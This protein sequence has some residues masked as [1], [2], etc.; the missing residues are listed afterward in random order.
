MTAADRVLTAFDPGYVLELVERLVAIPSVSGDE[1]AIS[2][3]LA[4]E[5][6]RLG[7]AVTVQEVL[8]GRRN[9]L[10][11][12]DTGRPGPSLLFNG[13]LDTLPVPTG[14][15]RDP[16]G[17]QRT[18]GRLV[19]AEVNNMK[20]AIGAMAGALVALQAARDALRGRLVLSGVI[21]ECDALGLGTTFML[22][23]GLRADAA[24]NGE[25]TDLRI[26]TAH[27]GVTQLRLT[28]EGR[29]V[30]VCQ[31]DAGIDAIARML[32]LVQALREDVLTF[33]PH[34]GF[35]GLPTLNVGVLRGGTLPSMLAGSCEALVDVRTV[36]GMTPEGVLVDIERVIGRAAA[37]D[38]A[39]RVRAELLAPPRFVQE[40]PFLVAE[41]E[42]IIGTVAEAHAFLT[43]RAPPQGSFFPQVFYG[44]DASHLLHAGIPTA[45][46]GPGKIEDINVPD[47]GMLIEDLLQ[48]GRVY[49]LS[50]LAFCRR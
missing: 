30:H 16:F 45:I 28:V 46:Y 40:P 9:V 19:G 27:A 13:H 50:A 2:A 7:F 23:Q 38:P 15:T 11:T 31:R 29:A 37:A 39:L 18:A 42:P 24:I 5:M 26:M 8:P 3:F 17:P 1:D 20:G 6:R 21:G 12:L 35:P 36:P 25:P 4:D 41:S 34:P 10:A 43:G 14:W 48:A 49:A 32:P 22:S 33:T 44:T 47:E